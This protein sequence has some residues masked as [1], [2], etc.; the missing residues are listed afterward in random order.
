[1]G[2]PSPLNAPP[3]IGPGSTPTSV[4]RSVTSHAPVMP[5]GASTASSLLVASEA[6]TKRSPGQIADTLTP[7]FA[8][9]SIGLLQAMGF[10]FIALQGF[11]LIA[12][13]AGE[14]K[15]PV[16]VLPRAMLYSLGAAL[17]IY[18]PF[19]FVLATVGVEPGGSIYEASRGNEEV[20]VAV[21]A[22]EY[23]GEFGFWFV[24]VAAI[25]SMLSALRA[26]LYAAS[27]VAFSMSRDRT[28]PKRLG[29][30]HPKRGT[31][32][33]AV[34]ATG[35]S[36]I[37]VLAILGD[38]AAAGAVASLIFLVSF[39][40]AHWTSILARTRGGGEGVAFRVPWFPYLPIGGALACVGLAAFQGVAVPAAG[41]IGVVWLGVGGGLY[42]VLFARRAR[43]VDAGIEAF[44][45]QLARLRG[46]SPLVLVP[47]ANPA[48]AE[49]MVAV[50]NALAPPH[51][52]R[53]LLLSV[54][55]PP[56]GSDPEERRQALVG[57]QLVL[58]EALTASFERHLFPEA[59]TT[60]A[61][62]PWPEIARVARVHR[63]E[64]LLVGLSPHEE[65]IE[66]Q[67]LERLIGKVAT[68]VVVLRAPSGWGLK[69]VG[70]ILVPVG[71]RGGHDV[72]RARL[73]GSFL[74][75]GVREITFLRI[76]P[77][78]ARPG[79]IDHAQ[80]E[81]RRFAADEVRHDFDVE[82]VATSDVAGEIARHAK[83]YD[84]V[85]LGLQ[86]VSRRHKFFGDVAMTIAR[87][88][89]TPL[90]MISRRG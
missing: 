9:G 74:R 13:V 86:R 73:L 16:R 1:L 41:L 33:A 28:L 27:R 25:L 67:P 6:I 63:C 43:V 21:A 58:R 24:T 77:E 49:A 3:T 29:R 60:I 76:L 62:E 32:G 19:L 88:T 37:V 26:N 38:V 11:D 30:I 90:I 17:S 4:R 52:G 75:M 47:I 45:P 82:I 81:L 89:D 64:S 15:N 44:D 50:A 56:H 66:G 53:V 10:T 78:S 55:R 72:F 18:L 48:N 59:M 14:V 85:I 84:L 35:A 57:A 22:G 42:L 23:L 7:F 80:E 34:L 69:S 2:S 46:R 51:V 65:D 39:A 12:A 54:V 61:A 68:D 36:V 83:E 40:L 70:R 31:P 87:T 20:I 8:E 71:G 79:Q 5:T